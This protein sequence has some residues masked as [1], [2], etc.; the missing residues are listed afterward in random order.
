RLRTSRV[1]K[2]LSPV[3]DGI[4]LLTTF[5]LVCFAWIF[6]RAAT[7]S[8]A[9]YVTTHLF[10]G[11]GDLIDQSVTVIQEGIRAGMWGFTNGLFL[12]LGNLTLV[13]RSEIALS[14]AGLLFFSYME[15]KQFQGN[16]L[17]EFNN[18]RSWIRYLCYSFLVVTILALGTLYTGVEQA[19]IY[20]Q[21]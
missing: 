6:F 16:A 9:A 1:A 18:Q 5:G 15:V 20:F 13:A 3:L 7:I 10:S 2:R 14:L 12:S 17:E 8:D 19:F 11:W 4:S 21:F